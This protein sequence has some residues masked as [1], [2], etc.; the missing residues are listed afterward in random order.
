MDKKRA[1]MFADEFILDKIVQ[2]GHHPKES[3]E[4]LHETTSQNIRT[5]SS[6]YQFSYTLPGAGSA[7]QEWFE[8]VSLTLQSHTRKPKPLQP[9]TGPRGSQQWHSSKTGHKHV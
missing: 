1:T 3:T 9:L 6:I 2:Q 4:H 7:S 8:V 5:N